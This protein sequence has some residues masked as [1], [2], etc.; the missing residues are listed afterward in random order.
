M[1][2]GVAVILALFL[3]QAEPADVIVLKDGTRRTGVIVEEND[4]AVVLR[5][6]VKGPK[7]DVAGTLRI[8]RAEIAEIR[9]MPA[10]ARAIAGAPRPTREQRRAGIRLSSVTVDGSPWLLAA[11]D[12]F[13]VQTT[14]DEEF[15]REK[16]KVLEG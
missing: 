6:A 10:E 11:G 1:I 4:E 5:I 8:A 13:E 9:R 15:A 3:G 2:P 14:C 16:S 12:R 7:G